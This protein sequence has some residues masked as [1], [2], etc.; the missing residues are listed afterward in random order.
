VFVIHGALLLL[1]LVGSRASFRLISEFA[2]R[3]RHEGQRLVIYGTGDGA[4]TAVRELVG[5]SPVR[6]RMLGFVDDDPQMA[7]TRIQGYPVLGDFASL[8]SLIA[9]GA[10]DAVV[11]TAPLID[12]NRLEQLKDLCSEHQVS[13]ARLHFT[14]DQLIVAS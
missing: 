14:L 8:V 13:L 2:Q 4:A 12:V 7:R 11:I 10:V 9:N 5:R 1:L 6:Y 3:R